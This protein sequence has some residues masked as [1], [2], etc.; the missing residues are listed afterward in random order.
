MNTPTWCACE[1]QL[2][3]GHGGFTIV[4]S[5]SKKETTLHS[6]STPAYLPWVTVLPPAELTHWYTVILQVYSNQID[7]HSVEHG[8]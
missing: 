6:R 5:Y 4:N 2:L 3:A 1:P 8:T 7:T